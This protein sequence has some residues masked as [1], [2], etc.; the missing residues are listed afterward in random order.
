MMQSA[1]IPLFKVAMSPEAIAAVSTVL[2]SGFIAEGRIVSDFE[3]ALGTYL[4]HPEPLLTNDP[5]GTTS[6]ALKLAGVGAGDEVIVSP[7]ACTATVMPIAII[8]ARPVWCDV[9][10]DSGMPRPDHIEAKI[11]PRTRAILF[12]HW[13]GNVGDIRGAVEIGRAKKIPVIEDATE[14]FG[15]TIDGIAL[16]NAGAFATVYSLQAVRQ[17]TAGDGAVLLLADQLQRDRARRL[18]KFGIDLKSFRLPN[19]EINQDSDIPEPGYFLCSNNVAAAIGLANLAFV[20][21]QMAV[22]RSNANFFDDALRSV[23]GIQ[24]AGQPDNV[25]GAYWTYCIQSQNRD[26]L[27][28]TLRKAGIGCQI[29]HVRADGYSCF[30]QPETLEGVES[31]SRKTLSLPCGWWLDQNDRNHIVKAIMDFS[32]S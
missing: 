22:R 32:I 12:Y 7:L 14:A 1:P 28:A 21:T 19:G 26:A 11:T 29:L 8:G 25:Q 5:S 27:A 30:G 18:R 2:A 16:G 4:N 3:T 13:N 24:T 17:L 23:P 31:F 10:P 15:A 9:D 20:D 6:L